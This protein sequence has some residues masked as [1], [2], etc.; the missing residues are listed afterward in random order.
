MKKVEVQLT[1]TAMMA[2]DG[3][4]NKSL[5]LIAIFSDFGYSVSILND[6]AL[7]GAPKDT[8]NGQVEVQLIYIILMEIIES[9]SSIKS[10]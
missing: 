1:F 6:W 7:I 10:I 2:P 4:L 8:S 3:V 9:N 5:K